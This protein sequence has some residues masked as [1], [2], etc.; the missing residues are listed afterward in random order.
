M[1]EKQ[2]EGL[3][4]RTLDFVERAIS[5]ICMV[6][7]VCMVALGLLQVFFRYVVNNSLSFSEE[8][9]IFLF[10]WIVF[11]GAAICIRHLAHAAVGMIVQSF[12]GKTRNMLLAIGNI[13]NITFLLLLVVKGTEFALG[14]HDQLS[15]A[16]EIPMSY[17]Y[18]AIP[19]GSLFM[20]LFSIEL[21]LK[22][23]TTE[24]TLRKERS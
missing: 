16:M 18:I 3:M 7:L 17:V 6:M 20:V 24:S 15:I 5:G 12:K 4:K 8:L 9:S 22:S 11:L 14:A 21:L 10:V 1:E 23:F 2:K 13:F 19:I